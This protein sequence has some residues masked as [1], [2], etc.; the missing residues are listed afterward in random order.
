LLLV[1]AALLLLGITALWRKAQLLAGICACLGFFFSGILID[2]AHASGPAPELDIEG[3]EIVILG[4]CVV[5][6]P[7]ISGERERFL[8]ELEPH[9]RAQVTLYTRENETLPE[10]HYGKRIELDARVRKPHNFGNPGAFDYARHLARKEICWTASGAANTVRVLPGRCGCL[11]QQAIMDLRQA[12][13]NRMARLYHGD[14]Y[15]TGMM[16]RLCSSVRTTN[17][18]A[19]GPKSTAPPAPST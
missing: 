8:L 10:I 7:A 6:P 13:L 18:S 3:R 15:Q 12:A 1:I 11:F 5:E 9:A 16:Q 17:C 19:C 2:V 4:G 14:L